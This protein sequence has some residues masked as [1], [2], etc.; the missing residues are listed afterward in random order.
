MTARRAGRTVMTEFPRSWALGARAGRERSFSQSMALDSEAV[1]ASVR[2]RVLCADDDR[3]VGETVQAILGDEGY[4]VTCLLEITD[5]ALRRAIGDLE[6][7][8]VLLDSSSHTDYGDSWAAAAW[9]S[10]LARTI[11]VVMFSAHLTDS[12]E[13]VANLS[14]RARAAGFAA[15]LLKPFSIDQLV[16]AVATAVA[17]SRPLDPLTS[18]LTRSG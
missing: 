14:E 2:P 1:T 12:R 8:C 17:R 18:G 7:D 10:H 6:P 16:D 9:I 4:D 5:A 13:A 3:A 15:V 11:P